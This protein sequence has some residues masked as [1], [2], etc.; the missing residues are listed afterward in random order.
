MLFAFN[1]RKSRAFEE[2]MAGEAVPPAKGACFGFSE[3]ESHSED[4]QETSWEMECQV[5]P[6]LN[7]MKI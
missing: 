7:Q 2:M 3:V 4:E 5:L 6:G 1:N